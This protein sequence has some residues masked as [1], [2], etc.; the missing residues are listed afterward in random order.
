[1]KEF[2]LVITADVKED[3]RRY[4][5]YI[6]NR[7]KNPQAIRNVRDDFYQTADSLRTLAETIPPANSVKMQQRGLKRI[8]FCSHD[9][10]LLF[11][12]VG[13]KVEVVKMFHFLE[14]Y[15]N[16]IR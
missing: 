1:M 2:R 13:D 9:Y 14:D 3:L 11:R 8:N 6:R 16:K 4:L 15:E 7:F 5:S 12:I 10:F